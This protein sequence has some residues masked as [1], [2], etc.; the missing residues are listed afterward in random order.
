MSITRNTHAEHA[1]RLHKQ[2]VVVRDSLAKNVIF[3]GGI[4][5]R[6]R[7]EEHGG[8]RVWEWLGFESLRDYLAAP[9]ESGGLDIQSKFARS[10]MYRYIGVYERF[11]ERLGVTAEEIADVGN[12][13]LQAI[14]RVVNEE[15]VGEWIER[16]RLLSRKDLIAEV[17]EALGEPDGEVITSE[18]PPI[19]VGVSDLHEWIRRNGTCIICGKHGCVPAHFPRTVGAGAPYED[20]VPMCQ[21]PHHDEFHHIGVDAF[22]LKYKTEIF[23]WFLDQWSI[24]KHFLQKDTPYYPP[25]PVEESQVAVHI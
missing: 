6:I 19:E 13:K 25:I 21:V 22:I 8:K 18:T 16:A 11:V 24:R 3:L 15:N 10:T 23:R 12:T 9:R 1:F 14:S 20:V 5:K 4:L 17:K 7:D 2:A